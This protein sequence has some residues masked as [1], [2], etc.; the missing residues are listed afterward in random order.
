MATRAGGRRSVRET[1]SL[2]SDGRLVNV[3]VFFQLILFDGQFFRLRV[4]DAVTASGLGQYSGGEAEQLRRALDCIGG[5]GATS[6]K[7]M[8]SSAMAYSTPS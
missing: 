6:S 2:L 5:V 3:L 1:V 8:A 4:F 7:Y